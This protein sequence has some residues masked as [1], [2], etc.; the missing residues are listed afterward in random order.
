MNT[1]MTRPSENRKKQRKLLPV[2]SAPQTSPAGP[3]ISQEIVDRLNRLCSGK[4]PCPSSF[5]TQ[6]V[7][8]LKSANAECQAADQNLTQGRAQIRQM[9]TNL[10]R[11]QGRASVFAE[12]AAEALQQSDEALLPKADQSKAEEQAAAPEAKQRAAS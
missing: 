8:R 1:R 6:A 4:D 9:E 11:L 3:V 10:E 5:V 2:Q 12:M 7:S